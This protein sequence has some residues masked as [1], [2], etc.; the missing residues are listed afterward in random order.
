MDTRRISSRD[1]L[2]VAVADLKLDLRVDDGDED[3]T[4]ERMAQSAAMLVERRSGFVLIP[5]EFEV[6]SDCWGMQVMR[7][8]FRDLTLVSAMT[9]PNVWTDVDSDNLMVVRRARGANIV[10]FATFTPPAC[11]TSYS[12]VRFRFTA[13]FDPA[14]ESGGDG[15]SGDGDYP[16]DPLVRGVFIAL[17]GHFY[18]NRELFAAD[19]LTEIESTAG[20][21]L[22]AIRQFW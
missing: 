5:G 13:G 16:L 15:E 2:P 6:L 17:V 14:L 21:L 20:G 18:E 11:C 3:A 7:A 22:N 4:L 1:V 8:P 9:E 12:G 10:P 19:K